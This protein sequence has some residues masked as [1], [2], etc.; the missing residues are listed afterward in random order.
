MKISEVIKKIEEEQQK[1]EKEICNVEGM[2]RLHDKMRA[3]EGQDKLIWSEEILERL[4]QRKTPRTWNTGVDELDKTLGGFRERQVIVIG[5][6]SG[7]GKTQ[8]GLFFL[9]K[10][11]EL[12]PVMI[13]IEQSNEEI[14]QQRKDNGYSIPR[15]LSPKNLASSVTLD[16]IEERIIEGIAKHNTKF[17]LIDHLGYIEDNRNQKENLAYRIE[18]TMKGLKNLAK[19]WD[20]VICLLVHIS[21]TDEGHPPSTKDI[22]NS[23]AI[24]QEADKVIMIWRKN[25]VREKIRIYSNETLLSV[26]KNRQTGRLG[27]IGLVFDTVTGVY[28]EEHEWINSLFKDDDEEF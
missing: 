25:E 12:N 28:K 18:M 2:Q 8:I 10:M 13:P 9:E 19:K 24:K 1:T 17:I 26:L 22:K 4:S 16:W 6:D 21:Q 23:S 15:F 11:E 7:H 3:Y 20:V 5:G 27:N 14:I